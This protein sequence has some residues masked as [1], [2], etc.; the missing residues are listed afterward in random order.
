MNSPLEHAG[1]DRR[2]RHFVEAQ[3]QT[4]AQAVAEL[5]GG[6]KRSHWMWFIFPQLAGLGS[7]AMAHRY[8][9]GS[10]QE[11]MDYL[12]HPLLGPRLRDITAV[13]NRVEHRTASQIFGYP[14]DLKFHSSMT[15]F[16]LATDRQR[17][18][19]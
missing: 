15:L 13:V 2:F 19:D 1:S 16:S 18:R 8:A 6:E 11:A 10:L 17:D 4:Y 3:N 7:S 5:A 14:D 9:L 12:W